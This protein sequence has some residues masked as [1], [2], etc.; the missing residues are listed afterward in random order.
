MIKGLVF[1]VTGQPLWTGFLSLFQNKSAGTVWTLSN[2]QIP[3]FSL[4]ALKTLDRHEARTHQIR[5]CLLV[6]NKNNYHLLGVTMCQAIDKG[7][8]YTVL[9]N[10][11]YFLIEWITSSLCRKGSWS[12]KRLTRAQLYHY[13]WESILESIFNLALPDF[14]VHAFKYTHALPC[15]SS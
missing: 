2:T 14:R 6:N 15:K 12:S 4:N 13:S 8:T 5:H 7:F 9:F 10:P 11:H 1:R 3:T